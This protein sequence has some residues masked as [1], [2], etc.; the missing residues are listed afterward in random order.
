MKQSWQK[1]SGALSGKARWQSGG[2]D[3]RDETTD[4]TMGVLKM[5][6]AESE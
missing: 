2:I 1:L 6:K 3:V 4:E 5:E